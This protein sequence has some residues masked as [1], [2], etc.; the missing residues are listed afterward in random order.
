M[1]FSRRL[2]NTQVLSVVSG[3]V[4]VGNHLFLPGESGIKYTAR[5]FHL[6]GDGAGAAQAELRSEDGTPFFISNVATN[7]NSRGTFGDGYELPVGSG[8]RLVVGGAAVNAN[9]FY[10]IAD[11]RTP[12]TKIAARTAA[13]TQSLAL[14][15]AGKKAIRTPSSSALGD[16]S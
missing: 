11:C 1:V 9:F 4:P 7:G 10:S 5:S 2:G 6:A 3:A 12:P 15:A 16:L 14:E 8:V 13:Y